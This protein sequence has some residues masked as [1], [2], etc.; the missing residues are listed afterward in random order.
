MGI[1]QLSYQLRL[2][3]AN[4]STVLSSYLLVNCLEFYTHAFGAPNTCHQIL[5]FL[6]KIFYS[7]ISI[8]F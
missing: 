7:E 5:Q 2:K 3:I 4:L 8:T 1:K 6:K